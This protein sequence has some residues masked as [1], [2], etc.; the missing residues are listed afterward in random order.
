MPSRPWWR[1]GRSE[2]VAWGIAIALSSTYA[3]LRLLLNREYK[4]AR[5]EDLVAFRAPL[6]FGH[7]V[8]MPA[9]VHPLGHLGVPLRVAL[10]LLELVALVALILVLRRLFRRFLDERRA[11]LLAVGFFFLLPFVFLFRYKWP[12]FYPW[13]TPAMLATVLG[14]LFALERR[15]ALGVLLTA[16]AA[17]NRESALLIPLVTAAVLAGRE[18]TR[19]LVLVCLAM[20]AAYVLVKTGVALA[21][22]DNPGKALHFTVDGRYRVFR[23]LEWLAAPD[24]MLRML[25]NLAFLPLLWPLLARLAP[26]D[27]RRLLLVIWPCLLGLLVVA[28]AYEPRA[29]GELVVLGWVPVAVGL[30]RWI[31]GE[32]RGEDAEV[33]RWQR[34]TELWTVVAS[35]LAFALFVLVLHSTSFLPIW[36]WPPHR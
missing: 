10:G 34:R 5:W 29:F 4:H 8:L 3:V 9:L 33:P 18:R 13:D 15:F 30:G 14:L 12:I 16:V 11:L 31:A 25:A 24:H 7:R 1:I 22:P 21:L 27:L 32:D 2:L 35:T 23:N 36:Q 6:P 20:L 19:R 26:A 17:A 28:N